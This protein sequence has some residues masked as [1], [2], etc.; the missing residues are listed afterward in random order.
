MKN[1]HGYYII[2]YG[3]II[4]STS[5][6]RGWYDGCV[7]RFDSKEGLVGNFHAWKRIIGG[8]SVGGVN[9]TLDGVGTWVSC[10]ILA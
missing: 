3:I 5:N 8:F 9:W 10:G 6:V 2:L 1:N 7:I 4:I